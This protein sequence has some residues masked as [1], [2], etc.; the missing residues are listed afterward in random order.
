MNSFVRF[1]GHCAPTD[2]TSALLEHYNVE[3]ERLKGFVSAGTTTNYEQARKKPLLAAAISA[4][5]G[6]PPAL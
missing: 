6:S 5:Y 1:M 4:A 3:S 2:L